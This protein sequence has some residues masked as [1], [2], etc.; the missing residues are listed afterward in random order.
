MKLSEMSTDH[1]ADALVRIA[2]PAA[3]IVNDDKVWELW[4][5]MGKMEKANIRDQIAFI[6]RDIA[7]V[8]LKDH[9]NALYIVLAIMTEKTVGQIANQPIKDTIQDIKNSVDGE[10]LSFFTPSE[11]QQQNIVIE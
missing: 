6:V 2:E 3:E 8:L 9:R 7:P 10:L 5:R 11:A 1:A 4:E